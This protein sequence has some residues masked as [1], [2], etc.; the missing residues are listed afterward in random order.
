MIDISYYF[1]WR[2]LLASRRARRT[3]QE[4]KRRN[5]SLISLSYLKLKCLA[6]GL[7]NL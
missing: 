2:V 6:G 5:S 4:T 3:C 7:P 1:E